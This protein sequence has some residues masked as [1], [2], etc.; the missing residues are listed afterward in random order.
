M[1]QRTGRKRF[2]T[3]ALKAFKINNNLNQGKRIRDSVFF[4]KESTCWQQEGRNSKISLSF[5]VNELA[6]LYNVRLTTDHA[7]VSP[8]SAVS[9]LAVPVRFNMWPYL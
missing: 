5:G 7:L 8:P 2:K 3:L 4:L 9:S 1:E 6:N